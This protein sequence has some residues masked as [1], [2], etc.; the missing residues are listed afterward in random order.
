M[1]KCCSIDEIMLRHTG[2]KGAANTNMA[3]TQN[4]GR[5]AIMADCNITQKQV[6]KSID[7]AIAKDRFSYD[8]ESGNLIW[9][10][11]KNVS[12]TTRLRGKI[13]G[14]IHTCTVG[15][16]YIQVRVNDVLHYAHRIIWVMHNGPI[17][18]N[19]QIDHIDGDGVNNRLQNLRIVSAAENKRNMRKM[20]TNTS[21]VTGVYG[22][23]KN[24]AY[25]AK[26]W[27]N[28]K[29]VGLGWFKEIDSAIAARRNWELSRNYHPNHG[30]DRSL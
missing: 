21:G 28:G 9:K 19:M 4:R 29:S 5:I 23:Y 3:L 11:C 22:P 6:F 26:G 1:P 24:G 30:T 27:A 13:A 15:K 12:T 14:H 25:E 18:L 10:N 8:A 2:H 7:P 16:K 17:P 20:S